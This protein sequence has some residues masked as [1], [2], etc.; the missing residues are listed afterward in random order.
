M[1]AAQQENCKKIS[2]S[3]KNPRKKYP[4]NLTIFFEKLRLK[5]LISQIVQPYPDI[6]VKLPDFLGSMP[7]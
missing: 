2:K 5:I 4:F 7:D 1:N 3:K 6:F